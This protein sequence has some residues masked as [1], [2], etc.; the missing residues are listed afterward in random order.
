MFNLL[1]TISMV[2]LPSFIQWR[3]H[4]NAT[5][6]RGFSWLPASNAT[7]ACWN[8][9]QSLLDLNVNFICEQF[10]SIY[11]RSLCCCMGCLLCCYLGHHCYSLVLEKH[12][13][14]IT[15]Y[16]NPI[17][18]REGIWTL[19]LQGSWQHYYKYSSISLHII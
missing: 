16:D 13:N 18:G 14:I 7:L 2:L 1:F 19:E 4:L 12:I 11:I 8:F 10:A 17:V 3:Q 6:G 9:H 15:F 5:F